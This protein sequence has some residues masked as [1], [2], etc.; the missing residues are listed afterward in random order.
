M[1]I[2]MKPQDVEKM[3][4]PKIPSDVVDFFMTIVRK[5]FE[6]GHELGEKANDLIDNLFDN[7]K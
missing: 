6:I 3:F 2:I 7:L 1:K 5:G 4:D